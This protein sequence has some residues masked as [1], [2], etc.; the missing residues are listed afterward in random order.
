MLSVKA[1]GREIED[2]IEEDRVRTKRWSTVVWGAIPVALL[3]GVLTFDHIPGTDISLAVPYAAQGPGPLFDTLSEV[4]GEPVVRI[5]GADLDATSG[6]LN[7]TTVSVRT[8]MTLPQAIGRW[9]TTDDTFV[10]VEQIMPRD[11]SREEVQEFNQQAFVASEA[12]ATVAAMHYLGRP[13]R[14]VVHDVVDGA[15]ASGHLEPGDALVAVDGTEITKPSDVQDIVR[16]K[17][18]GDEVEI[19]AL[20]GGA[21]RQE[22]IALGKDE[23][24]ENVALL[25]ILMS[26]EPADG[27]DVTYN[28]QDVGGPS[29]GMIFALAVIDKLSPGELTGGKT[30]AGTGTINEAGEVGPIGGISHKITGARDAGMELFL[31]PAGNCAEAAGV[32]TGDM[33]VAAV[34]NLDEA[35]K[36]MDDYAAGRE[37]AT[38]K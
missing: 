31:A 27:V 23:R 18:P 13:T 22:R 33:V 10:P 19:T 37:V 14:V 11:M 36:A 26:S 21:E 29:A 12:S 20:R 28:L 2:D 38:C 8:N 34:A 24:D 7:M 17:H 9:I 25:G 5:D 32:E 3:A 35:V 30:V 4:S 16:A 6:A 15:A 1:A